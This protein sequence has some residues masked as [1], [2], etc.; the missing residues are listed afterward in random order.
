M[1]TVLKKRK[2]GLSTKTFIVLVSLSAVFLIV[3]I[4]MQ[5]ALFESFYSRAKKQEIDKALTFVITGITESEDELQSLCDFAADYYSV[6]ILITDE[7]MST[8]AKAEGAIGCE[9]LRL[10]TN[11]LRTL[12]ENAKKN[13]G[14]FVRETDSEHPEPPDGAQKDD[15]GGK[16]DHRKNNLL[17]VNVLTSDSGTDRVIFVNGVT[18]PFRIMKDSLKVQLSVLS[19]VM[20][21]LSVILS[22]IYSKQLSRPIIE[23]NNE[24]DKLAQGDFDVHFE[25][26]SGSR[27]LDEL[28]EKLNHAAAELSK[29][30]ALRTEL[31][32]NVSH[33]LRTPLTLITGY[34]EMMRDLP[35]EN[36]A[37]NLNVIIEE[38]KRLSQI[39]NDV[40]DISKYQSGTIK[41][42][43]ERFCIT[44]EILSIKERISAFTSANGY[45]FNFDYE[46][47]AFVFADRTAISRVLYNLVTNAVNYTDSDSKDIDIVQTVSDDT[48]KIEVIDHGKGISQDELPYVFDRYYRS[49]DTHVRSVLGSGLG[50]SIVKSI[51]T[52]HD[53]HFGVISSPG[54]GSDFWFTLDASKN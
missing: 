35:G 10:P 41:P 17:K 15:H 11:M 20:L 43:K 32:A 45:T 5:T 48:V 26:S 38:S 42:V 39:V 44:D 24:A 8:V 28:G 18:T 2:L 31:I 4:L 7:N 47:K 9:L 53:A 30:D 54:N 3:T 25:Q 40:L 1:V 23:M 46:E 21:I 29:V 19:V 12:Y 6:C 36:T 33:D 50:L 37:E 52:A 51:L 27:E 22:L 14:T 13:G 16:Q 49:N 34:S